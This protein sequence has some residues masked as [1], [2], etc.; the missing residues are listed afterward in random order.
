MIGYKNE[1]KQQVSSLNGTR[2]LSRV[3]SFII[4]RKSSEN[5]FTYLKSTLVIMFVSFYFCWLLGLHML[6]FN[7]ALKTR[8]TMVIFK[9][10]FIL[11]QHHLHTFSFVQSS[12]LFYVKNR[13][14]YKETRQIYLCT[15]CGARKIVIRVS[16]ASFYMP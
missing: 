11:Q 7:K 8:F 2:D 4:E 6:N 1:V 16:P 15:Y 13:S 5:R 9:E 14:G 10:F 3:R 12:K